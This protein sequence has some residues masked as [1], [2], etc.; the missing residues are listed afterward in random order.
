MN[1]SKF[2]YHFNKLSGNYHTEV[3]VM[4]TSESKIEEMHSH[5]FI[6]IAFIQSGNG[7]HVL[8][9]ETRRCYPG[10]I[11]V[12]DI[13]EHHMYMADEGETLIIYNLIF[14][15]DFLRIFPIDVNN[16]N[17]LIQHFLL[18]T[19]QYK[20]FSHSLS[21]RFEPGEFSLISDLFERML[22]EYERHEPGY[23]ELIRAWTTELIVYLFRKLC[24]QEELTQKEPSIKTEVL[25]DVFAYIQKNYTQN[26]SLNKLA[27]LAFVSPKYF[28]RLFKTHTG[29]TVS[30]YTQKLRVKHA[31]D[32]L[33]SS[34]LSIAEIAMQSGYNDVKYFNSVFQRII[35]ISP[36]EYRRKPL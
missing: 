32:L 30:E 27:T 5:D 29:Y 25:S 20:D 11:F 6:E 12:I 26:I 35:G 33:T 24:A 14:H 18:R 34:N 16:F 21:A 9:N 15:A 13:D 2:S 28:S 3:I 1:L 8:G 7:W 4:K 17:E 10:S 31:C 19:F 23:E 22:V 36:T